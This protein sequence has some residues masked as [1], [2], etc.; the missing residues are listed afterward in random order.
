MLGP[1]LFQ[2]HVNDMPSVIDTKT[3]LRLF[4]DDALIYRVIE[5]IQ[6]QEMFQK[7]LDRLQ[8][9]AETWG[10]V[11]NASKCYMMHIRPDPLL[12]AVWNCTLLSHK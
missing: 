5:S 7:D 9:W 6:D 2:L 8:K 4:A 12:P 11:F 3:T 10:M 1:L